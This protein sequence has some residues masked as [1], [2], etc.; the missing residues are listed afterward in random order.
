MSQ[1]KNTHA[2]MFALA[3]LL[4]LA[5]A[6]QAQSEAANSLPSLTLSSADIGAGN[7]AQLAQTQLKEIAPVGRAPESQTR[8]PEVAP[9]FEQPGLLTP[10]GQY[11][12]EPSLQFGYSSSNRVAL[13]GYS[14]IPALLIG[15]VDVREVKR[16]TTTAAAVV[17]TA[18]IVNTVSSTYPGAANVSV[19]VVIGT[20]G[21]SGD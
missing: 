17:T 10:P 2:S 1:I 6:A 18:H 5:G 14:I 11:V 16:N 21:T 9:I 4:A 13:V 15:L 8:P 7:A 3:G 20:G 12:L 19:G